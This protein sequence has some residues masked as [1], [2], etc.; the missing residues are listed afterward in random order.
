MVISSSNY[1]YIGHPSMKK[2]REEIIEYYYDEETGRVIK[3]I[4]ENRLL[5]EENGEEQWQKTS[6]SIPIA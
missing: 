5:S 3:K 6:R 4:Q 2:I 1:R